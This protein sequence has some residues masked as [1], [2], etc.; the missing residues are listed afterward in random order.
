M[1]LPLRF[2][3]NPAAGNWPETGALIDVCRYA[4]EC[5]IESVLVNMESTR[6]DPLAPFVVT[7]SATRRIRFMAGCGTG[8]ISAVLFAQQINAV[9]G[10]LPGRI[11]IYIPFDQLLRYFCGEEETPAAEEHYAR[12]REF[13]TTCCTLCK[14]TPEIFLEGSSAEAAVLAIKFADCLWHL[15]KRPEQVY[16]DALPVLHMGKEV[17]LRVSL[18]ARATAEEARA[19][20]S[21]LLPAGRSDSGNEPSGGAS[22]LWTKAATN[23]GTNGMALVGSF[24]EVAKALIGYKEKGISQFL[25]SG[26]PDKQEMMYFA[27]GVLPLVRRH[28]QEL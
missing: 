26:T 12:I 18:I 17:G 11:F 8:S 28:E 23:H 14:P 27:Q 1:G 7:G 6:D 24:E 20:A 9:L 21:M 15:P 2:H 4:E 10:L 25:F 22:C 5:G 19:T 16:S 3:W 13:L